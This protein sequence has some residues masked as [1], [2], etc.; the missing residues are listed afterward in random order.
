LEREK[1]KENIM[2]I[3]KIKNLKKLRKLSK[4]LNFVIFL[5]ID[6]TFKINKLIK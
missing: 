4:A 5:L 1:G 3:M 2:K 6:E